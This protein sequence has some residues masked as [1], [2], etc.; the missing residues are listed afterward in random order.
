MGTI[1]IPAVLYTAL[2]LYRHNQTV[3]LHLFLS[4]MIV[5]VPVLCSK[6]VALSYPP[7]KTIQYQLNQPALVQALPF[8]RLESHA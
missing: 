3:Q 2:V 5:T 7:I 1:D 4:V 6:A 8:I